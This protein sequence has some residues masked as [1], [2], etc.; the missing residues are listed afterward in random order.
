M[1]YVISHKSLGSQGRFLNMVRPLT[2]A[3]RLQCLLPFH[4]PSLLAVRH[5]K[6]FRD[7]NPASWCL[8]ATS[9]SS[10]GT[11]ASPRYGLQSLVGSPNFVDSNQ[12]DDASTPFL[13]HGSPSAYSISL[14]ASIPNISNSFPTLPPPIAPSK[15]ISTSPK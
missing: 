14:Y 2:P 12:I 3:S 5:K 10:C 9:D 11:L 15:T 13:H 8:A 7:G 4:P 6:P 1:I